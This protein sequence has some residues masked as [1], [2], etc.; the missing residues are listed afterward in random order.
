MTLTSHNYRAEIDQYYNNKE[1]KRF[2]QVSIKNTLMT[3]R[4][5][6]AIATCIRKF[7]SA[8]HPPNPLTSIPR[9]F[10]IGDWV[11]IT[12]QLRDEYGTLR[13][14]IKISKKLTFVYIKCVQT[15]DTFK[16][17]PVNLQLMLLDD[18]TKFYCNGIP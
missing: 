10:L 4:I 2:K 11:Q 15:G 9:W 5:N 16:R 14:V 8:I 3:I 13:K 18:F 12:N 1:L 7:N 6:E 17:A